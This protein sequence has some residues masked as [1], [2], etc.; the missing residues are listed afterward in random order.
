MSSPEKQSFATTAACAAAFPILAGH[1]VAGFSELARLNVSMYGALLA[2]AE[3]HRESTQ[4]PKT[5]DPFAWNRAGTLPPVAAQFA[6]HTSAV[7]DMTLQT[8]A[9][10]NRLALDGYVETVRHATAAI[11]AIARSLRITDAM[12]T[13]AS[14]S[15][16]DSGCSVAAMAPA[17]LQDTTCKEAES[18]AAAV[19][20][21][22]KR[23][24]QSR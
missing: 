7:M 6:A 23:R 8:S 22:R 13:A 24:S 15:S 9:A 5:L 4:P 2:G 18:V 19:S 10:L 17:A 3:N 16:D 14:P 20:T 1:L 12:M 21:G 11:A